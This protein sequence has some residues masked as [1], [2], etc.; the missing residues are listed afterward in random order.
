MPELL[1]CWLCG[2]TGE[3]LSAAFKVDS[4]EDIELAKKATQIEWFRSKFN[5]AAAGW[6]RA[7]PREFKDMDFL[8]IVSNPDQFTAFKVIGE[9]NDARRLMM[10]WLVKSSSALRKGDEVSLQSMSLSSLAKGERDQI[11][12]LMDQFEARWHRRLAKE[13]GEAKGANYPAGFQGIGLAEGLEFLIAG[14]TLYYDVQ[15]LLIQIARNAVANSQPK[16]GV[17]AYVIEGSQPTSVCDTCAGLI[18]GFRGAIPQTEVEPEPEKAAA[19]A[20]SP[21]APTTGHGPTAGKP[22]IA[23][24]VAKK[25]KTA[26]GIEIPP[27]ASPEFVDLIKKLGPAKKSSESKTTHSLHEH[28]LKEDWDEMVEKKSE[29]S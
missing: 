24:V 1:R 8:F 4:V 10:D 21:Q 9:I 22:E 25:G 23:P 20:L 5:E 29:G 7:A 26:E 2:R 11:L 14:G 27:E 18:R 6:R 13:E 19:P 17:Q 12:R 15:A 28:R 3:E 16:W